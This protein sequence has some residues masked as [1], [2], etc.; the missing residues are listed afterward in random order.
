MCFVCGK[1]NS[2]I[3]FDFIPDS[4]KHIS[5]ASCFIYLDGSEIRIF[6]FDNIADILYSNYEIGSY[7]VVEG[8]LI[9][10]G[11]EVIKIHEC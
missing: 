9:N 3:N 7:I 11:I 10:D 6:C 1:I 5:I 4:K 2:K 8:S